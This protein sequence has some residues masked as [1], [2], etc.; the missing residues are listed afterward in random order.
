VSSGVRCP[1]S[2]THAVEEA[3]IEHIKVNIIIYQHKTKTIITG[4][5]L[6]LFIGIE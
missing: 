1:L 3:A 4:G 2:G 5:I 6:G